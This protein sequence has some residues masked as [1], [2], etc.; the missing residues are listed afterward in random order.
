MINYG[1]GMIFPDPWAYGPPDPPER[2]ECS[3]CGGDPT[4][5]VQTGEDPCWC[6]VTLVS[7]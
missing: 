5:D 2:P 7:K 4:Q 1:N 3:D 6:G